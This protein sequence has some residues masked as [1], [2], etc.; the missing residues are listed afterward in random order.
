MRT[1]QAQQGSPTT[2][3]TK[4]T[5]PPSP[6]LTPRR[7]LTCPS[8]EQESSTQKSRTVL[9]DIIREIENRKISLG[10]SDTP[11]LCFDL[12]P[13]TYQ[14]WEQQYQNDGFVQNKLRYAL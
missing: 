5:K 4:Y 2:R 8:S 10:F 1:R 14:L 6:P 3:L 13:A 11:W 9:E 12:P 7:P